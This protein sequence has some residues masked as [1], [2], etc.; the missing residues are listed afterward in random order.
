MISKDWPR[1]FRRRTLV[2]EAVVRCPFEILVDSR[3]QSPYTFRGVIADAKDKHKP[4]VVPWTWAPLKTGDYSIQGCAD[5]VTIERKSLADL[6]STLGSGRERFEREHQRMSSF[7]FAAVVVEAPWSKILNSPP[8]RSKLRPRTVFR[9]A[10]A[11]SIRYGV[12]WIPAEDRRMAELT[13][14]HLLEKWWKENHGNQ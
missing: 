4:V 7:E 13:T 9:T 1:P 6:Y 5:R 11:W 14:F 8:K 2:V 12:H 3:E 10:I